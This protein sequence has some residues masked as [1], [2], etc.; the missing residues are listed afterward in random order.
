MSDPLKTFIETPFCAVDFETTGGNFFK[1]KIIEI[2]AV[3]IEHLI[4]TD[5]FHR[6]I[7]PSLR[8]PYRI[9]KLTGITNDMVQGCD[10][11]IEIIPY[12]LKFM[13]NS[14]WIEHS[15]NWFDF[16]FFINS[17]KSESHFLRI[18]TLEL[19]RQFLQLRS[20]DLKS[21]ASCLNINIKQKEYHSALED[22][23]LT[24]QIFLKLVKVLDQNGIIYIDDLIKRRLIHGEKN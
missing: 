18:N 3:K 11:F 14:I 8:I 13:G 24:A 17:C 19:S 22:A 10:T 5:K 15:L 12:F 20:L 9:T 7:D 2:G 4:I 21:I 6:V 23:E 16:N 1:D